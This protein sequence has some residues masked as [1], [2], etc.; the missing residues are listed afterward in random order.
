[1]GRCGTSL[2]TAIIG[3]LGVDLGPTERMLHTDPYD[4][5]RGYWEQQ[6]I[7]EINE[8]I[9]RAFGGA[10]ERPPDLP[11]GWERSPALAAAS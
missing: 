5:A 6:E 2:T 4:N 7:Y 11:S 9:L 8:E 1:M 10:W 3:L